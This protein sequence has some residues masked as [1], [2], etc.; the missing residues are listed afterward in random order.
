MERERFT[1]LHLCSPFDSYAIERLKRMGLLKADGRPDMDAVA[2]IARLYAGMFYNDLCDYFNDLRNVRNTCRELM[3][4]AVP[5]DTRRMCQSLATA[6]DAIYKTLPEPI[7]WM[8]GNPELSSMFLVSF[9]RRLTE[10][11]NESEVV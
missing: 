7:W 9:V 5:E 2:V 4:G 1:G 6:Y 3:E 8:T 11:L 10:Y